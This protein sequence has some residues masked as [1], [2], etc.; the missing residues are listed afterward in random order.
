MLTISEGLEI[1]RH[2]LGS[3]REPEY[4][5]STP[6][7]SSCPAL[8]DTDPWDLLDFTETDPIK[9]PHK[10]V[11]VGRRREE[12]IGDYTDEM[13][14]AEINGNFEEAI[15]SALNTNIGR[16]ALAHAMV[17]GVVSRQTVLDLFKVDFPDFPGNEVCKPEEKNLDVWDMI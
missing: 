15:S 5:Y 1:E 2:S 14:L 4:P 13:M 6:K 11:P 10:L 16:E 7:H 12:S 9:N 17:A 3:K 8:K